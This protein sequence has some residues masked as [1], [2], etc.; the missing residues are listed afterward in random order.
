METDR[1]NNCVHFPPEAIFPQATLPEV[2]RFASAPL[3]L[4]VVTDIEITHFMMIGYAE[5]SRWG[6]AVK[7]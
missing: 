4:D 5:R 1:N 3:N 2:N 6:F 7:R